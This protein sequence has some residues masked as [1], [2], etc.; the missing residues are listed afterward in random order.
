MERPERDQRASCFLMADDK[1]GL[2]KPVCIRNP[3]G[4]S[5]MAGCGVGRRGRRLS[6]LVTKAPKE[7]K[8]IPLRGSGLNPRDPAAFMSGLLK[9]KSRFILL[10]QGSFLFFARI[11]ALAERVKHPAVWREKVLSPAFFHVHLVDGT[12]SILCWWFYTT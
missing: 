10:L 8:E 5:S 12:T 6:G 2:G 11:T 7:S 9:Y 1:P 3:P 4:Y